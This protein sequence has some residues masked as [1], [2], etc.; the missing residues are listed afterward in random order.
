MRAFHPR[1]ALGALLALLVLSSGCGDSPTE[2]KPPGPGILYPGALATGTITSLRDT[3][4]YDLDLSEGKDVVIYF[5]VKGAQLRLEVRDGGGTLT[6]ATSDADNPGLPQRRFTTIIHASQ[7]HYRVDVSSVAS[8]AAS[9]YEIRVAAA[10]TAPEHVPATLPIGTIVTGEDLGHRWDVD[11]FAV[12]PTTTQLVSLY[13]RKTKSGPATLFVHGYDP[14]Q[15]YP[16]DLDVGATDTILGI[17]ASQPFTLAAGSHWVFRVGY[18]TTAPDSGSTPYELE[19]RPI[20]TAPESAPATLAAGDSLT[21][22][23]DYPRDID[24]F[25]L[26]GTPGA[27]FNLFVEAL[28]PTPQTVGVSVDGPDAGGLWVS[29]LTGHP[30]AENATGVF[31]LPASGK[32]TLTASGSAP[33]TAGHTNGSTGAY[34]VFAYP[35]DPRPEG[36]SAVLAL[37]EKKASQLEMLGDVDE[38]TMSVSRDTM[39]NVVVR[40]DSTT[41]RPIVFTLLDARDSVLV[42]RERGAGSYPYV[43]GDS[44]GM[45]TTLLA[46]GTYTL[47]VAGMY[48][49]AGG[50]GYVGPYEILPRTVN[51]AP[52]TAP[53]TVAAGDTVRG[54]SLDFPGDI[55]RFHLALVAGDSIH[56]VVLDVPSGNVRMA[57]GLFDSATGRA[58]AGP[59]E[60]FVVPADGDYYIEAVGGSRGIDLT[61][62]GGYAFT[63]GRGSF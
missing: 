18:G 5:L 60:V 50:R 31:T 26:A 38:L 35:I 23:I 53:A 2:P 46:A 4:R 8:D 48:S 49:A 6:A 19:L 52:E 15:Y 28:G 54:E 40:G 39:V 43:D 29:A 58:V 22:S 7:K 27:R 17:A 55:D 56:F 57:M 1:L 20:D 10:S 36:T 11:S 51:T 25:T 37:D 21:E 62:T 41:G 61:E 47:R 45:G 42:Q 3:A 12:N 16:T 32:V 34:R 63:V 9:D 59:S 24:V 14:S 13:A 30:L 44:A 33:G